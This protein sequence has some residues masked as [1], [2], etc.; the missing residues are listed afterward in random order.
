MMRAFVLAALLATQPDAPPQIDYTAERAAI[1]RYQDA[2]QR[3]QDVGWHLARSNAPFCPRVVPSIGLQLQDMASYGAPDIARAALGL[4][5][6]FAVQT[7]AHGSPSALS[8]AFTRNREI[9][10]LDRFDPND[11]PAGAAMEWQRLVRAHDHIDAMLTEHGG[12]AITFAD[13]AQTRLW[14]VEVCATRFE[15]MGEGKAAVADGARVVIGIGFP[16]FAYEDEPLFAALVAHELAHNV[17][18]HD[19]WLDTNG[20]KPHYVRRIER[21]ADRLAP[22]LLA[23]AGYDPQAAVDF[24]KRWGA[25]HDSGLRLRRNHEGWD[26]RAEAME[27]EVPRVRAQMARAGKADWATH[28]RREIDPAGG[29]LP[30]PRP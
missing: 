12:I 6:D 18:G 16:A 15:L 23:N 28:F 5:R 13:G 19:A 22:W 7:A 24:M 27:G 1:A 3:L 9:D 30:Q 29:L 14:P 11:W 4:T 21:E 10:R 17:L 25:R 2:D 8:G 20:R 26:E